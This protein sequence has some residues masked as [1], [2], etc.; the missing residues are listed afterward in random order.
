MTD[1][2]RQLPP[3]TS[4]SRGFARIAAAEALSESALWAGGRSRR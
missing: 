4:M 3:L 2:F 1:T